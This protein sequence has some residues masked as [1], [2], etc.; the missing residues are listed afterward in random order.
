M[1]NKSYL[2]VVG[3]R[4][5]GGWASSGNGGEQLTWTLYKPNTSRR[6]RVSSREV[7][8][9][10]TRKRWSKVGISSS[11]DNH[12][13]N[14]NKEPIVILFGIFLVTLLRTIVLGL[15]LSAQVIS[16]ILLEIE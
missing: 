9:L 8:Q 1:G 6:R 4:Q 16:A 3:H 15:L 12:M 13:K 7:L 14:H 11:T 2:E 10:G 5:Q